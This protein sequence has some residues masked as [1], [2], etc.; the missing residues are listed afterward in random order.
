MSTFRR[1]N[2]VKLKTR[3][4]KLLSA[5]FISAFTLVLFSGCGVVASPQAVASPTTVDII[6]LPADQSTRTPAPTVIHATRTPTA[7]ANSTTTHTQ[8]HLGL[9][10]HAFIPPFLPES[11]TF[12]EVF[13][14]L[15]S[16][17]DASGV[18]CYYN[19]E[20][21]QYLEKSEPCPILVLESVN[22]ASLAT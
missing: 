8:R 22:F 14:L 9:T 11:P 10:H 2:I 13:R 7:T 12:G 5:V 16:R 21:F 4:V 15:D 20:I 1:K 3:M 6:G 17:L 19:T 18:L